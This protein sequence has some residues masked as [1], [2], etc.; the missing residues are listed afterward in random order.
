MEAKEF[1]AMP[2]NERVAYVLKERK[3]PPK[4]SLAGADFMDAR[5]I[6]ADLRGVDFTNANFR[7]AYLTGACFACACLI[8]ADLA[9]ANLTGAD[10]AHMYLDRANFEGAILAGA[11][12]V[13]A[14][15]AGANFNGADLIGTC[16][17]P[18][19]APNGGVGE[20][21]DAGD[22][23][24][25]G[26]RT[27]GQCCQHGPD[28]EDGKHYEAPVFS[29]C[30]ATVCHPGLY[31]EPKPFRDNIK[32]RLKRADLH[33]VGGKHRCKAFDVIGAA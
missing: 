16:L 14:D 22:G 33:S 15:L 17:D 20:W 13:G 18:R 30:R 19:N 29:T 7:R 24:G 23:H 6:G 26:Y 4:V 21:E 2:L 28:Y 8:G 1:N 3:A 12:F 32:V 31:V 27:R 5:L 9:G 10:L 25:Y 11:S